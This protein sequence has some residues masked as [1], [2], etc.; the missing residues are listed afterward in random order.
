M[1]GAGRLV[2]RRVL[3]DSRVLARTGRAKRALV[4]G[5]QAGRRGAGH[6]TRRKMMGIWGETP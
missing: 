3:R 5:M 6:R 4:R 1:I 2:G